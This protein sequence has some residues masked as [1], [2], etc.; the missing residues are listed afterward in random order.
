MEMTELYRV[1]QIPSAVIK[2]LEAYSEKRTW[3]ADEKIYH[4]ILSRK[5]WDEGV[6]QLQHLIG[7]D[8]EGIG[9]L[10][11][12]LSMACKACDRYE[13]LGIEKEIFIDTMKFCT[14][15]LEA[16]YRLYHQYAFTWAWWF[17]RQLSLQEFR[18]GSL[19]YEFIENDIEK[20]I[21][22]HIPSDADL[23]P[24]AVKSSFTEYKKFIKQYFPDWT[25]IDWYCE[26]WMLSPVLKKLLHEN[27]NILNFQQ[28][29]FVES[30][31]YE[32][33][34]VLDWVFPG[35]DMVTKQL[36]E[37]TTLQKRMKEYLLK[38]GKVGWAKGYIKSDD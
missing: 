25:G 29:F 26:S 3:I 37:D 7:E 23:S 27:S 13:M 15:F 34:A 36:P 24:A 18:I 4:M 28:C 6:K 10:W 32:S 33:M 19:E 11:E 12:M 20:K 14:R 17:P 2:K 8:K 9:I 30:V 35:Y 16:H 38:G 22:I 31:D 5:N 1:L 21:S